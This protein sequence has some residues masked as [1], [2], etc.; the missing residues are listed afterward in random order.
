MARK[1][2]IW[3]PGAIYHVMSRG[4]RRSVIF[5]DKGD[6]IRFLLHLQK[7]QQEMPFT[8][9]SICLMSNHF[10]MLIETDQDDVSSIMQ[11]LLSLY[12]EDYNRIHSLTGHVFEGR[13]TSCLIE[14]NYYFLEVSRYIHL[15]P[16]KANIV[17]K[18]MQYTYSS[19]RFFVTDKKKHG[20]KPLDLIGKLIDTSRVL[21]YFAPDSFA[22]Y[23]EFVEGANSHEKHELIIQSDIKEDELW[24]PR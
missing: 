9:H 22:T 23:R 18:P 6:Y 14:D 2:R 17:Y 1:P 5:Q 13:F 15:N 16:V 8:L 24:L 10:H 21:S 4:N 20:V 7:V 3:Y 11:K 12:A 19:Y